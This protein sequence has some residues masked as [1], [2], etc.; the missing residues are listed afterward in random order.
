[1]LRLS[2]GQLRKK[3]LAGPVNPTRACRRPGAR[4]QRETD[5]SAARCTGARLTDD[6]GD[7]DDD[8]RSSGDG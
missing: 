1:M 3:A 8:T 5:V 6:D 2:D 4:V 7:D